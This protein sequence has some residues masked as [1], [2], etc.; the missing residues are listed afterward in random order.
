M[1]WI[2]VFGALWLI[3]LGAIAL[4]VI[5]NDNELEPHRSGSKYDYNQREDKK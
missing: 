2:I 4:V 1:I 3:G 5:D